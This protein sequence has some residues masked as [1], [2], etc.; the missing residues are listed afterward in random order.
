MELV[1]WPEAEER[2]RHLAAL[3]RPRLLLVAAGAPPPQVSATIED[4]IRVPASERDLAARMDRLRQLGGAEGGPSVPVLDEDAILSVDGAWVA[5]GPAQA[6]VAKVLVE[7]AQRLVPR[8]RLVAATGATDGDGRALDNIVH[9]LRT[10]LAPLGWT[11]IGIRGRGYVLAP[12]EDHE[13]V[14][15]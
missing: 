10:R 3:G 1:P 11:I 6:S 14:D 15:A 2:R 7:S 9:R 8:E 5:L 12:V 4:W 13:V